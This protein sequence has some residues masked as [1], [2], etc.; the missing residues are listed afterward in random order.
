MGQRETTAPEWKRTYNFCFEPGVLAVH[1]SGYADRDGSGYFQ[2]DEDDVDFHPYDD[3]AGNF[4]Q[5]GVDKSELIAMR[6]FLLDMFPIDILDA[7][8]SIDAIAVDHGHH[9]AAARTMKKIAQGA[10]A[11]ARGEAS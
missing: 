1:E 7:L 6:D 8:E 2:F 9:E 4:V 3:K 11:K 5:V 10:L